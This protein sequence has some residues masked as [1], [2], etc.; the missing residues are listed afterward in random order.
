MRF[1]RKNVIIKC[2]EVPHERGNLL[3]D[4]LHAPSTSAS[5]RTRE[6]E[7]LDSRTGW[8]CVLIDVDTILLSNFV[9]RFILL[10]PHYSVPLDAYGKKTKSES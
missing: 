1:Q 2:D 7:I 9:F 6:R 5:R 3:V 10:L 8:Q 4:K